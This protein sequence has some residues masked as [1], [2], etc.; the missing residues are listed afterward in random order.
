MATGADHYREAEKYLEAAKNLLNGTD[1]ANEK[2]WAMNRTQ[3]GMMF[4]AA[5]IHMGLSQVAATLSGRSTGTGSWAS[6]D[7]GIDPEDFGEDE[8]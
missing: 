2:V 1:K 6:I 3:A 5:E 7:F 8:I 4:R